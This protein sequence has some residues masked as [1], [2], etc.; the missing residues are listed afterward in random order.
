M[1][2]IESPAPTPAAQTKAG[3]RSGSYPRSMP[4]QQD[5]SGSDESETSPDRQA[6]VDFGNALLDRELD[7]RDDRKREQESTARG[8]VVTSGALMTIMLALAKDAGIYQSGTSWVARAFFILTLA[9]SVSAAVCGTMTQ[10]PR[11]FARLG[12]EA[13]DH[14]TRRRSSISRRMPFWGRPSARRSASP[15][16]PI[17]GTR[18]RPSGSSPPSRA[19]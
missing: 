8:L 18:R 6:N 2:W 4:D 1:E 10:R 11:K 15:R 17:S 12:A 5:A 19:S 9:A 3:V 7:R 13:L 16:K 14:S